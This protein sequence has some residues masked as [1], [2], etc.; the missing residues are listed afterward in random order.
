M[1]PSSAEFEEELRVLDKTE[2][3]FVLYE[4]DAARA[5]AAR[6]HRTLR[7]GR[8]S[9][10]LLGPAMELRFLRL[11]ACLGANQEF[12]RACVDTS[13]LRMP[14]GGDDL[15]TWHY[16]LPAAAAAG[17][18]DAQAS[19]SS[20][21][22]D[23]NVP[24]HNDD[25][26]TAASHG[27][28][29]VNFAPTTTTTTAD[30]VSGT[31]ATADAERHTAHKRTS[32][33]DPVPPGNDPTEHD[34]ARLDLE[35][36]ESLADPRAGQGNPG[37]S[38]LDPRA[39]LDGLMHAVVNERPAV[40]SPGARDFEKVRATLRLAARD[41]S[42][43]GRAERASSYGPMLDALCALYPDPASR[44]AVTV[45][46][47]GCG[48]GRLTLEVA[49]LGFGS[50]GN[51]FSFHMLITSNFFLNACAG[52]TE[53]CTVFPWCTE[54]SNIV[55]ADDQC[56]GYAVPDIDVSALLAARPGADAEE[57]P[58]FG[59]AQGDFVEVFGAAGERGSFAAVLTCFFLDTA[60]DP[61]QY[62]DV[63]ANAV[64]YGGHW[65]NLGPLL[66]HWAD[67]AAGAEEPGLEPTWEELEIIIPKLG[68]RFVEGPRFLDNVHYSAN[69]DALM[70]T[71][72]RCVFFVAQRVA[73]TEP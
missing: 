22:L 10:D 52:A 68:F 57:P 67:E 50:V 35:D 59:M 39:L 36:S 45:L 29:G 54:V 63:I 55:S 11:R 30:A 62:I 9:L 43:E 18:G 60:R 46:T 2:L 7:C 48:L 44:A 26:P 49:A 37:P 32:R 31:D 5:L 13:C 69:A 34:P 41:W 24:E 53:V 4:E 72:Y 16:A 19:S 3:S 64:P 21:R 27:H 28:S 66:Y 12:L 71:T 1:D 61:V 8:R 38:V 20:A 65:I 33:G 47:P 70:R 56:R 73:D 23:E 17:A 6:W 42:A 40:T 15:R 14:R 25:D 58:T 51:E